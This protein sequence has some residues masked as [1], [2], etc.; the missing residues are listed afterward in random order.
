[1]A[2]YGHEPT[3][4]CGVPTVRLLFGRSD[5]A[6]VDYIETAVAFDVFKDAGFEVHFTTETGNPPKCDDRMLYGVTGKILVSI[7]LY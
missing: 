6:D 1:M 3:G 5:I 4:K 7:L 2:D